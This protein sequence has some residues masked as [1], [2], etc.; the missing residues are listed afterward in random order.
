MFLTRCHIDARKGWRYLE[1]PQ[2]LHAAI[3]RAM[4]TQPVDVASGR[5][6]W[7]VDYRE[8]TTPVLWIVSH[9]EPQLDHFAKEAGRAVD[10]V[11]YQTRAY[12]PLLDQLSQGQ[13]YAFR[14]TANPTHSVPVDGQSRRFGHVT[15]LQQLKWLIDRAPRLGFT[16]PSAMGEPDVAVVGGGNLVF[17]RNGKRVTLT[18]SEFAGH[19]Q[20]SD[21]EMLRTTLMQGIGHARAYG[22]GLLTVAKPAPVFSVAA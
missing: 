6:L 7:R 8:T 3:Y 16:F 22:C 4:P 5:P 17:S 12:A 15:T 2:R 10:G 9:E 21:H 19:L 11:T 14:L 20:V 13:T 18:T 1:S